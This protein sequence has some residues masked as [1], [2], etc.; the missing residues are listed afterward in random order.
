MGGGNHR[1][2]MQICDDLARLLTDPFGRRLR[3]LYEASQNPNTNEATMRDRLKIFKVKDEDI[4]AA[5]K[6]F[7]QFRAGTHPAL[8]K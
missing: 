8:K 4:D 6:E 3:L 2:P 1:I 7:H 5:V